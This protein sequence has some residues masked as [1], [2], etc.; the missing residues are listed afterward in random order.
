MP[1]PNIFSSHRWDYQND[2]HS[3]VEKLNKY[4][5]PHLNY[6]VP[7]HNP[8][9]VN[10]KNQIKAALREQVRQCNYFIIFARLASYSEWC[11]FEVQTAT[12]FGKPILAVKPFEYAGQIP[13]FISGAD[14]QGGPVGFNAPS[15]IRKIC[16]QLQWQTPAGL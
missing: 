3:L 4:G 12:D 7:E 10:R 1:K 15:I 14:N 13:T 8:L 11:Q 6:S 16:A 2:Y 9:D 5:F